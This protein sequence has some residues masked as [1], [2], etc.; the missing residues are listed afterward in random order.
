MTGMPPRIFEMSPGMTGTSPG[1][2]GM[3]PEIFEI[4]LGM[5][6]ISPGAVL[7]LNPLK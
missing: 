3:S 7:M 1:I 6:E 2:S 4:S 5:K